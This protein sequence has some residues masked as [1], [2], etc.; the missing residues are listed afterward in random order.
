MALRG[1]EIL[2]IVREHKFM[3]R[4]R[5]DDK[6]VIEWFP[7]V[8]QARKRALVLGVDTYNTKVIRVEPWD[9]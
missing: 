9:R 1:L 4:Y 6:Y 3:V 2:Y 5:D 7:N 8:E